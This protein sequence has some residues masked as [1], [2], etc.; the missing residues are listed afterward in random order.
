MRVSD[1][2]A[3]FKL[4]RRDSLIGVGLDRIHSN[5]YV[6]LVEMAY[7]SQKLGYR[8]SEIPITFEERRIGE[9]KM[10]MGVK[11]EAAWRVWQVWVRHHGLQ[12][13]DRALEP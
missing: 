3:G 11:I 1:P 6:F 9:S 2:T 8:I 10:S 13:K 7:V 5:G 4:W 12:P